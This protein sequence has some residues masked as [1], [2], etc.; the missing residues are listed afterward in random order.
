MVTTVVTLSL[1][2]RKTRN[3][4]DQVLVSDH[5]VS[6]VAQQR[7]AHVQ[8]GRFCNSKGPYILTC[9]GWLCYLLSTSAPGQYPSEPMVWAEHSQEHG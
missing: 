6:A 3:V 8:T 5:D 4:R 1:V 2:S 7:G 9:L